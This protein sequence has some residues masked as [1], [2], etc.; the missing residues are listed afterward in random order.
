MAEREEGGLR[1]PFLA[2]VV[3]CLSLSDKRVRHVQ[4]QRWRL[5]R[6]AH[7]RLERKRR[8]LLLPLPIVPGF[9]PQACREF[10]GKLGIPRRPALFCERERHGKSKGLACFERST[11]LRVGCVRMN[12]GPRAYDG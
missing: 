9:C 10:F 2:M 11:G 3:M 8:P 12:E 4:E 7:N 1:R 6:S 5:G